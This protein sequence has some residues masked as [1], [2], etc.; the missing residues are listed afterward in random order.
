M[1]RFSESTHI[2]V[3]NKACK[4]MKVRKKLKSFSSTAQPGHWAPLFNTFQQ[5]NTKHVNWSLEYL[6]CFSGVKTML[7]ES[8]NKGKVS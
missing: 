5:C 3:L 4:M 6:L 2:G 1:Q 7:I 8:W